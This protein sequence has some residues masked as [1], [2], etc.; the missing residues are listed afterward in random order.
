VFESTILGVISVLLG[1]LG[2]Y[3]FVRFSVTTNVETTM[4]D[5]LLTYRV[6]PVAVLTVMVLGIGAVAAAPVFNWRRLL[7][8]DIPSALRVME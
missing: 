3:L 5:I 1:A 4:P 8:L 7:R 2:G 6:T